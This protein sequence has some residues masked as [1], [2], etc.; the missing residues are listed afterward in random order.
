MIYLPFGSVK[1]C[2]TQRSVAKRFFLVLGEWGTER[3]IVRLLIYSNSQN[4]SCKA[5]TDRL[6]AL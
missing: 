3:E 6:F 1:G 5:L 4:S 2:D